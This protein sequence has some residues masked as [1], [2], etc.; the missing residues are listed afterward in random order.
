MTSNKISL[1]ICKCNVACDKDYILHEESDKDKFHPD[2]ERVVFVKSNF[3]E[4]YHPSYISNKVIKDKTTNKGR[5]PRPPK[6]RKNKHD[7]GS[8][9][10]FDSSV[11][12]GVKFGLSVY[13]V[14]V[15]RKDSINISGL[16]NDD[17]ENTK[18][19]VN[20]LV[21]Y[22]NE[23]DTELNLRIIG[24]PIINLCNMSAYIPSNSLVSLQRLSPIEA[25]IAS[26]DANDNESAVEQQDAQD[27]VMRYNLYRLRKLMLESYN[28][29]EY[30]ECDN[31]VIS[32]NNS[33]S[34]FLLYTFRD[35][36]KN[37]VKLFVD[38]KINIFGGKDKKY[39]ELVLNKFYEILTDNREYLVQP[40]IPAR[41]KSAMV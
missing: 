11:T 32:Y 10:Q 36:Q 12:F 16:N 39:C 19:I 31:H 9:M 15:F 33:N 41:L 25:N 7:K 18:V 40:S 21:D 28:S 35:N 20:R 17:I 22:L 23:I 6:K 34:Y 26:H 29:S 37:G 1:V 5:K 4:I 27:V 14:I 30:W 38:G 2:G 3:V 13:N 8:G 24:E